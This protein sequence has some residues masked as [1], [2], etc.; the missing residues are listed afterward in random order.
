VY[1]EQDDPLRSM[2]HLC[3][4]ETCNQS[5]SHTAHGVW[6]RVRGLWVAVR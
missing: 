5:V 1:D 3:F 6:S 4:N 2:E